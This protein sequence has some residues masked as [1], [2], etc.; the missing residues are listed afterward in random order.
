[1]S[2]NPV[3]WLVLQ[4]RYASGGDYKGC[5]VV[6]D[7]YDTDPTFHTYDRFSESEK[8]RPFITCPAFP[9]QENNNHG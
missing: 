8:G 7:V 9:I 2:K 4:N 6:G 3:R 5:T 1:M